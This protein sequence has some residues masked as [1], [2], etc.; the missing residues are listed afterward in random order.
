MKYLLEVAH[1]V[2]ILDH[3]LCPEV[4]AMLA[5]MASRMPKGGIKAR[6]EQI[7][8]AVQETLWDETLAE[9]TEGSERPVPSWEEAKAEADTKFLQWHSQKAED[10][11]C[12]YPLPL[13]VRNPEFD[14]DTFI[15]DK[16]TDAKGNK[17]GFF[18]Q[19]VLMYGHGSILELTGQ[20][21]VYTE[22]ISW[23]TAYQ[24][25]DSPLCSG[26][27]FST[28]AVRHKDWPMARECFDVAHDPDY[29][30]PVPDGT[31]TQEG[32]GWEARVSEDGLRVSQPNLTLKTLHEGW[33]EVFEAELKAWAVEFKKDC[34][35]CGGQGIHHAIPG[36]AT[37][38]DACEG[39]G[40]KY[41]N[42]DKEPF[43]PALDRA[44][45]AIPGTI[46]TGCCHTG[47]I[48]ERARVIHD[49]MLLAQKGG[50]PAVIA[51]W[52][53]IKKGYEEALP[54]MAGMGLREAVY[55]PV[56]A[57]LPGHH[58]IGYT[59]K[60]DEVRV[61]VQAR[62]AEDLQTEIDCVKPYT[63]PAGERTYVDPYWNSVAQVAISIQ[64]SLAVSR[65]WHRH[66][67]MYP[68]IFSI[69]WGY[70]DWQDTIR[71]VVEAPTDKP[72][73]IRIH[74][75]YEPITDLGKAKT[76]ELL[77]LSSA[78][79]ESFMAGGDQNRAMLCL[80]LGTCVQMSGS[81]GLRD[82]LYMLELRKNAP[83]ANFEYK[84]QA[85]EALDLLAPQ[86]DRLRDDTE[87]DIPGFLGLG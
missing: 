73:G 64:C 87:R 14:P 85:T 32:T 22:D 18:D 48:R 35:E 86:L 80:P 56:H 61:Y 50:N 72:P 5:A 26:Q 15:R 69:V 78:A 25:F 68:W 41:P 19:F 42:F 62:P 67:T 43:R 6:Y 36:S 27:E 74:H 82:A 66:R 83:G 10:R 70:E 31:Y 33:F 54:G 30:N 81:A 38:C 9:S 53:G 20:P 4:S 16:G 1:G 24:L 44:R 17:P 58:N 57:H 59:K 34:P 77:R 12:E 23:Y 84:A 28:R 75:A 46:A 51:V 37:T 13:I 60:T 45:W 7:V 63:R 2:Y 79:Y 47:Y 8:D 3:R 76:P 29:D 11:L 49:G 52:D 65:D 21:A 55:H 39:T 71:D 40:K